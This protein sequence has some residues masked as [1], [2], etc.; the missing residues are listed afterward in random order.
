MALNIEIKSTVSDAAGLKE[1]LICYGTQ[2]I[3]I[4]HQTD[5]F[6]YFPLGR[7][8]L[9]S[10][11]QNQHELII[12]FRSNEKKPKASKYCRI[13]INHPN[14]I[15]R[16]LTSLFGVRGIVDKERELFLQDS[17]RFHLDKVK[18]LGTFFEIEYVVDD[19][20]FEQDAR[21]EVK[22]LLDK[23]GIIDNQL[24]SCSYI[25]I[26]LES[27]MIPTS[28]NFL[29]RIFNSRKYHKHC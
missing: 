2:A 22:K 12:Y 18:N 27:S 5:I 6:Y 16:M 1:R 25:D 10:I 21:L 19:V 3:G 11:D 4:M 14:M 20:E 29:R 24:I 26:L 13:K 17:I 23:L 28:K 8:K 9:R 15:N 7:L